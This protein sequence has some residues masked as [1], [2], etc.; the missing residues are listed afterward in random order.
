MRA[1]LALVLLVATAGAQTARPDDIAAVMRRANAWQLAHP[2]MPA[3]N[4]N[5]ERATWYTGVLA[6]WRATGEAAYLKQA[7]DW[8]ELHQWQVGTE[9]G[10]ANRLFC[11]Q[12]W[13]ELAAA[14]HNP[15]ALAPAI[16]WLDTVAPNSPSGA[17]LWYLEGGR[18]YADSLYG[19]AG[20]AMLAEQTGDP[21][22]REWMHAFFWDVT[23]AIFDKEVGL[24]YRDERFAGQ[25]TPRGR[26]VLW[27]RGN[28]WAFAGL[29]RLLEH[30]P[31]NDPQRPRYVAL[32]RTMAAALV[33]CQG[34]D[35]LWRPNL[36]D[37]AQFTMGESSGTGFFCHGLAWGLNRGLLNRATYLSSARRA[38]DGLLRSVADDG[39]VQWGQ[40]V[41][42]RPAPVK[43]GDSHE[44]VTGTLLLAG[45]E[46][47][48]LEQ[49]ESLIGS[50]PHPLQAQIDRYLAG[51]DRVD[52][53]TPTG[54]G[55]NDYLRIVDGQVRALRRYQAPN[56][57][58]P[59]PVSGKTYYAA[60]CYA[61]CVATLAASGYDTDADLLASGMLA[62]D[63]SVNALAKGLTAFRDRHPDFYIY[64]VMLALEQFELVAPT[65]R[66]AAWR[67][68]LA[69]IDP[70]KTYATYD[71]PGNNWQLVHAAGEFLR[72]RQ[73]LVD[74]AYVTSAL[75]RQ[76]PHI[77]A[78]GLYLEGG[79]PF[80]YD[81][82]SRYFLTG[83]LHHGL[84]DEFYRD[85][86]QRGAWTSLLIQSPSGELPT[87][88]RS[89]QHIWNEAELTTV[90]ETYA[91]H[92]AAAGQPALATAFKRGARLALGAVA[93]WIRADGSGY[94]VKNR[95][96]IEARFG[97][98]GYS[99][100]VNYNLLACTKLCA[101]WQMADDS[102]AE[103]PAP[104][105]V[106]GFAVV[107]PR[108]DMVIANAG[109]T[110]AQYMTHGNGKYNPSGLIRVHLAGGNPLLGPSDGLL[111]KEPC[112]A[113]RPRVLAETPEQVRFEVAFDGWG[114]TVTLGRD[115]LLLQRAGARTVRWPFLEFDGQTH[116]AVA[117]DGDRLWLERDGQAVEL[118]GPHWRLEPDLLA[119]R[120]G[121]VRVAVAEGEA[122][123]AVTMRAAR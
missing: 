73:G 93:R 38:W 32:F 120:N 20:L 58:L 13:A 108:F 22:Y 51:R 87:G 35:G 69:A 119:H 54:L 23:D 106:G 10:G 95:Y 115:G 47:V 53:F 31:A 9:S 57:E 113:G 81:A 109:G 27:A 78:E 63:Y 82:F 2:V 70:A 29:A 98:E 123:L 114:D 90:Y 102:I 59:D 107:L 100:H 15:F 34:D 56:G 83:M 103:G 48:K 77:T 11:V 84:R 42:D 3:G 41:G 12:T 1:T 101:A 88:Y 62:M 44:Y 105:D 111:D 7:R 86:C 85:A 43:A 104:A 64:P 14:T 52:G 118:S 71:N 112:P 18:H 16:R 122:P 40:L 72:A 46:M 26:R 79:A 45:S 97:Y 76:R 21:R 89:A 65:Q 67:R 99:E 66:L 5:W 4:R 37:P 117:N 6:A 74:P 30:L 33:K 39:K 25:R 28:G 92:Y 60:P 19:A 17:R 116:T 94:V 8:A 91:R 110:Y 121:L 68:A 36:D 61:H 49:P 50:A 55:R 80:A 96:P 24:Y 75:A